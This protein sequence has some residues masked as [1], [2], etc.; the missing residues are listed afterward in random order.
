M[1]GRQSTGSW[2]ALAPW[3]GRKARPI[4]RPTLIAM[5]LDLAPLL[6]DESL[7]GAAWCRAHS[8]L[9]DTWLAGLFTEAVPSGHGAA[10]V[11]VGG[12]GR[13]ELCPRSDVD[14]ILLHD[15]K[16][17]AAAAAEAIWYPIWD[18]GLHLGHNVATVRQAL[19]LAAKELE[20]ATSLLS[21]RHIAGDPQLSSELAAKALEQWHDRARRWLPELAN[22]VEERHERVGEVA[23]RLEPDLKDGRGGLRDVHTLRWVEQAREI[24]LPH[25]RGSL[26]GSYT[27]ILDARVELHRLT[28]RTSNVLLMQEQEAVAR[29]VGEPDADALMAHVAEAA[30]TISWTSDDAWRRIRGSLEGPVSRAGGRPHPLGPGIALVDGEVVVV[31]DAAPADD[32][33]LPLRAAAAAAARETVIERRSL[34]RLAELAPPLPSPWPEEARTLFAALLGCGRAAVPV[35]EALDQRGLWARVLPEWAAVRSRPQRN[36]YH[37]FTV[38]RHLLEAVANAAA[39]RDRVERPDLL[40]MGALFH[41]IGK[42]RPGDHTEVGMV[43]VADIA[44]RMGCPADDVADLV[45]MVEHHLLL[46]DVATRRDLAEARTIETVA[47]A[48]VTLPRLHLLAALTEADSLA[49]GASAWGPWKAGLLDELV[50][51]VAH[52]LEG[53]EAMAFSAHPEPEEPVTPIGGGPRRLKAAGDTLT[54]VAE[55]RPGLFST[56]AGVLALHGLEVLAAATM[57]S[58]DGW[59]RS[60]F[61]I[62]DPR[63]SEPPWERVHADLGRA[64]DGRLALRARIAERRRT[65]SK[66]AALPKPSPTT[67]TFHDDASSSATVIDVHA[68][69]GLGVLYSITCAMAELDLDIRSARAQTLGQSVVDSF[70]VKTSDGSKLDKALQAEAELAIAH[71]LGG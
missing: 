8:E 3:P 40:V 51:R 48:V 26:A 16:F 21:A 20:S 58:E 19:S 18:Q 61:K 65:Y 68:P 71:S 22:R 1:T 46:P 9:V 69:D 50:R 57:G 37:R 36:A 63:R 13:S 64:L 43:L 49:T 7:A 10:L 66:P 62:V 56:V 2:P 38:D 55:D 6:A 24:L 17:D 31:A 59:A 14:V 29:A 54:V 52:V 45:A 42:G 25:D 70:Y 32:A 67:I 12:Y 35:I 11:A 41:D 28:D 39:L 60:T 44:T 27:T 33:C 15:K 30:R 5:A 4:G 47:A 53:G 23:F 34:E